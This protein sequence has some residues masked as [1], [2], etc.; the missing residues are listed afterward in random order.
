[1]ENQNQY[2]TE[3]RAKDQALLSNERKVKSK[4]IIKQASL[5]L[6]VLVGLGLIVWGMV[7]IVKNYDPSI[8]SNAVKIENIVVSDDW[9]KGDKNAKV[10]IH[11]YADFE[12]PACAFYSP[13]INKIS[14]D[15][16]NKIAFVY[17]YFPLPS[18]SNALPTAYAAEAAGKQ[19]KFWEMHDLL[20]LKQSEWQSKTNAREISIGYAKSLGLDVVKFSKDIDSKEVKDRVGRDLKEADRTNMP[21]TPTVFINGTQIETPRSYDEFKE[22]IDKKLNENI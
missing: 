1:M 8:V 14:T 6:S 10:I 13:I 5:W 21:G 17:R 20:F 18:H 16:G 9:V 22:I 4:K 12:C 15:Y 11:E 19:G 7:I 3:K 2:E